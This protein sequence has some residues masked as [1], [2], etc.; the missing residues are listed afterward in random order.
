MRR[1]IQP[2]CGSD[3]STKLASQLRAT[4]ACI[5]ASAAVLALCANGW[6]AQSDGP[7][8]RAVIPRAAAP[9]T[10]DGAL[11]EYADAFCTPVEYFNQNQRN[12]PGQ[13][14]YLW[15]DEAF[16]VAVRTLDE[17]PFAPRDPF[18]VGDAV[19]L[20]FDVRRG[21]D[22]LHGSWK[23]GAVHCFFSGVKEA[24]VEPQFSLRPGFE[25][26]IPNTGVQVASRRTASGMEI[27]FKLPWVN[28]PDFKPAV[29]QIVGL[30]AE[31]SY[32]D[33]V[34]RSF[35]TFAFGGPL[36]VETPANLARARLVDKFQRGD[37]RECGPVMMPIRIDVPWNQR[38][39]PQVEAFVAMPPNRSA[40]VGRVE[41]VLTNL[42][43]EA[44]DEFPAD[45]EQIIEH[46][47]DFVRRAARWPTT[48]AASGAYLVQAIVYDHDGQ[49]LTRV[50]PRLTSTNMDQGY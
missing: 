20:Y 43:G 30:D 48:L 29:G 49:E 32:S 38:T 40:E 13:V 17:H 8:V 11:N 50:A 2:D 31:L 33:G 22:F 12:R 47:G 36:S 45:E 35:R 14:Y 16:F 24:A 18:W 23:K 39:P 25:D 10:I 34:S 1:Y 41:F 5:V 15:D 27:E 26:A 44:L 19:E 3:M 21:A 37:W 9:P 46:E 4:A 6:A 28:F 7:A 42:R